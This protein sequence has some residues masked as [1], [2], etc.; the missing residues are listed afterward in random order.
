MERMITLIY[1][2]NAA[3]T[4]PY[5]EVI[6]TITDVLT[7]H[8]GNASADNSLGHDAMQ[9]IDDVANQVAADINCE[10]HEIIWTSG[11]CEANSLAIMGFV[12]AYQTQFF[13]SRL[14]HASI[15]ALVDQLDFDYEKFTLIDNDQHGYVLLEDL[16][17]RL[18]ANV[19]SMYNSLVSISFA[20][21]EVGTIQP[22]KE[23]SKVVHRYGGILHVDA[24]Q[25][26]PWYQIDVVDLGID[27]M[28]VSAQ[29]FHGP[30][31]VGFLY[32]NEDLELALEPRIYGRQNNGIRGGTYPTHLIAAFGTALKLTRQTPIKTASM[33][34]QLRDKLQSKLIQIP[35]VHL[36][37]SADR[38]PNT[39]S[40]TIDG[41][42]AET[43]VTMC[44]LMGVIIAKGSACKSHE[45]TPSQALL[46]IGLTPEQA[47]N[48][49]RISLD[50]F[51]TEEEINTAAQII[52]YLVERIRNEEI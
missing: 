6:E 7:N 23:I 46:A 4:K 37:G 31:G 19:N 21:A 35:N 42:R 39:L 28:S 26:Y 49:I 50:E 16:E 5:P 48:T 24:T 1:L 41:V 2:D 32:I 47:L 9:I 11:A 18:S 45:P 12:N 44:D 14:E 13:T 52:T 40:L 3:G 34:K 22:I 8:W 43:L 33:V 27:M 29:K 10:P 36:N 20:N 38:L 15:N 17:N 51:N 25:V 30:K